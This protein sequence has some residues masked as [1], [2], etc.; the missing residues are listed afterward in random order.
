MAWIRHNT[1]SEGTNRVLWAG[2]KTR[3]LGVGFVRAE[4]R[5]TW[6]YDRPSTSRFLIE[7][8][9]PFTTLLILST[10]HDQPYPVLISVLVD[11]RQVEFRLD[12]KKGLLHY[13]EIDPGAEVNTEI[14]MEVPIGGL[15][16]HDVTVVVFPDPEFQPADPQQRLP[17]KLG[18]FGRRTV[19]CVEGCTP[20]GSALPEPLVGTS[21]AIGGPK[22]LPLVPGDR[23]P[24]ER[25]L[26]TITARAGASVDLELW[27]SNRDEAL[28]EYVV[29]PFLNYHQVSYAG[30]DRLL[31]HMPPD[32][33]LFVSGQVQVPDREGIH[34]LTFLYVFDPFQDI[35]AVTDPFVRSAMRAGI[36]AERP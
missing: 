7:E 35:E 5:A 29:V 27:A 13:L 20:V 3:G 16:W 9:A 33:S 17:P 18:A 2:V 21:G 11:Y 10:G 26:M 36:I 25:L 19:V 24:R 1:F 31:F 32:S 8:G 14:P 12:G 6:P 28:R 4:D 15:G 22:A 23:P 34:E 30:A